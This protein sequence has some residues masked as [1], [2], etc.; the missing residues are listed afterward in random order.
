MNKLCDECETVAYCLK[1]GCIPE[2]P[3]PAQQEPVAYRSRLESGS[4]TYCN[5]AQFFDNAEPLYTHPQAS[6]AH[7]LA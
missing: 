2:Q 7:I 6:T 3:A 1:H 4:Y 5:T